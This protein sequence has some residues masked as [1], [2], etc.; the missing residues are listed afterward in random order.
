MT[1][2]IRGPNGEVRRFP[3]SSPEAIRPRTVIVRPGEKLSITIDG[4]IRVQ[5]QPK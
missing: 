5:T 2:A 3:V 4:S 1:V